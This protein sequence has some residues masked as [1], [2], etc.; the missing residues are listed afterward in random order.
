[1]QEREKI[2]NM[3]L[4]EYQNKLL[5]NPRLTEE[6]CT[7]IETDLKFGLTIVETEEYSGRKYDISQMK[8]YSKCLRNGYSKEVREVI[9]KEGLTGEQMAVA[10]E[11]YEKGVPIS[12]VEEIVGDT[13]K[14]AFIM[15]RLLQRIVDKTQEAETVPEGQEPEVKELLEQVREMVEKISNQEERYNTLNETLQQ[16]KTAGQDV[17]VQNNL[18]MQ[19]REK[20]ELLEKQ[21]NEINEARVT[22]ARLRNDMDGIQKEKNTLK[23]TADTMEQVMKQKDDQLAAFQKGSKTS[24]EE[25]T[26]D[27][28]EKEPVIPPLS[29]M[30]Y[31]MGVVDEN[32]RL[33]QMVSIEPQKKKKEI[34][35][36]TAFFSRITSKKKIDL[37]K[38]LAQKNLETEQL[39]QIKLA[40]EKGLSEKQLLVLIHNQIPAEQMEEII[41]I[42]VLEN[43]MEEDKAWN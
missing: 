42:A 37:V 12:T 9:A 14:T 32:G 4:K 30:E 41:E 27:K 6:M 18:L 40:I 2:S 26:A 16:V 7:L 8:V 35:S 29:D 22:I 38:L 39:V 11:F 19:L 33:L 23:Q 21:Q 1:M 5:K 15:K 31:R 13:G 34:P 17:T 10:L 24:F 20:D 3:D 36:M 25:Q 28:E 43:K